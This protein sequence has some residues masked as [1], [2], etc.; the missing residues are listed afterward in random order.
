MER[1][2]RDTNEWLRRQ[3]WCTRQWRQVNEWEA[4]NMRNAGFTVRNGKCWCTK[5]QLWDIMERG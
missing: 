5:E 4:E 3:E 1:L 2:E